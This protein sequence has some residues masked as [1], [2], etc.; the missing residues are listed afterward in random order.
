MTIGHVF[1]RVPHQSKY[2][3]YLLFLVC[4]QL[5]VFDGF[6][7]KSSLPLLIGTVQYFNKKL[8]C[9]HFSFRYHVD[10]SRCRFFSCNIST[11]P[12]SLSPDSLCGS[13][14]DYTTG[15]LALYLQ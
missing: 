1:F 3:K 5:Y 15:L 6:K 9:A 10:P 2:L 11:K 8:E 4:K 7:S 13:V 12:V 14:R